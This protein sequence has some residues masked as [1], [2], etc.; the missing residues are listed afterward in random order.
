MKNTTFLVFVICCDIKV[1]KSDNSDMFIILMNY[2]H[3]YIFLSIESTLANKLP[4]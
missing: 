1:A 4:V 3:I 2:V